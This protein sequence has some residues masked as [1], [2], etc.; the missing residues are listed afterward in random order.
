[1]ETER[2]RLTRIDAGDEDF[3]RVM[4]GDPKVTRTLGGARDAAGARAVLDRMVAHWDRGYGAWIV[5]ERATGEPVGWMF[6][7]DTDVGGPG[8]VELGYALIQSA[9]GKGYATEAG[10]AALDVAWRELGRDSVV[11]FTLAD[12]RASQAV[13]ARLGFEYEGEVEHAGRPHVLYRVHRPDGIADG[14]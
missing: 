1:M 9:W 10:R 12:N 2:L 5:R 4:W 13:M 7:H 14:I 11:A 8:G 3:V 6:L